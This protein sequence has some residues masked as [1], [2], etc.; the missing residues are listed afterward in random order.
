MGESPTLEA[1]QFV[2]VP[3]TAVTARKMMS[4]AAKTIRAIVILVGMLILLMFLLLCSQY[5]A[6]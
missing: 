2:G 5:P 3:I 4:D 6:L 1:A